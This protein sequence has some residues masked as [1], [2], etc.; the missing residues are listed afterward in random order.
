[1]YVCIRAVG[2]LGVHRG[3][4]GHGFPR[5]WADQFEK[6][7]IVILAEAEILTVLFIGSEF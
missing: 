4:R 2:A 7:A 3:P 1:M 5:F 6:I